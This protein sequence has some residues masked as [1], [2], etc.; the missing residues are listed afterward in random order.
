MSDSGF[1]PG[2]RGR[3][4][5]CDT[6]SRLV[7]SAQAG[8]SQV[9]VLRG[10]AGIGKTALLEFLADSARGC[11]VGRAAGDESELELAYSGLHQLCSPDLDRIGTLPAPQRGA[12]HRVRTAAGP[13]ASRHHD[14]LFQLDK[15]PVSPL[16]SEG[17]SPTGRCADSPQACQN[18]VVGCGRNTPE[19]K[20]M[21]GP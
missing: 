21:K 19:A 6:L 16:A 12:R 11:Q 5:E 18:S 7:A 4:D 15:G 8:R 17:A 2:L 14:G 13:R 9:L 3:Q 10:E 1:W 20:Y